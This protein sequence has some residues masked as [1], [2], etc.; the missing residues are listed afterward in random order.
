MRARPAATRPR[1]S[2]RRWRGC[3]SAGLEPRFFCG[4]GWYRTRRRRSRRASWVSSTARRGRASRAPA[5][6]R[7]RIRSARWRAAC[8]GRCRR[9]VHAYFH[10]FD[11]LD[12][13]GGV[14]WRGLAVLPARPPRAAFARALTARSDG[15]PNPAYNAALVATKPASAAPRELPA[16][17]PLRRRRGPSTSARP[18]MSCR[19]CKSA[20]RCAGAFSIATL[21]VLDLAALGGSLYLALVLRALYYGE[22]PILW[23][24]PWDAE[25]KWLPFLTLVTVLVFWRAGLYAAREQR[26]GAGPHRLVAAARHRDHARLRGRHRLPA[27]DLRP[28]RDR[29]RARRAPDRSSCARATRS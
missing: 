18:G 2:A 3:A 20:R 6:C 14:P 29:V 28:V 11:L 19:S 24:L 25:A 7:R 26:A 1:A 16:T 8:S 27:R 10:D 5:S 12:P 15:I 13:Y 21:M 4:G 9:Y 22:R 23:G 17:T